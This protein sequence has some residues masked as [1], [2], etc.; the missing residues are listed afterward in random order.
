MRKYEQRGRDSNKG[1][2]FAYDEIYRLTGVK[3]NSPEPT[4]PAAD[5]YEKKKALTFDDL[6]NIVSIVETM[7]GQAKTITTEIPLDSD[8][9]KLNQYSRFDQ[10]G[11][12]Y[13]KNGNLTQ[14][15]TQKLYHDYRNRLVRVTEG[16]T[17]TENKYDAL[18]RRMQKVVTA[19]SQSKTENYY[20]AGHQVIEVRDGNDQVKRQFIY[21]NG[22]DEVVRLDTYNGSTIAPY[23]FHS[24]GIG[25]TTAVTEA[26]G[27]VVER[28]QYDFYGMPTFMDA[29]SN[30]IPNSAI[31]NNILFQGREYEPE[32]NFYYY[33][34]RHFDPIM[35]R[36]LQVDPMGYQDSLN[37]YQ[38]F[39]MNPL[40]FVD[41]M[42]LLT[43][44][45]NYLGVFDENQNRIAGSKNPEMFP[46]GNIRNFL[47][48]NNYGIQISQ[49]VF[50]DD[51]RYNFIIA[52]TSEFGNENNKWYPRF[53]FVFTSFIFLSDELNSEKH[54]QH[55]QEHILGF[56][57]IF[58]QNLFK[59]KKQEEIGYDTLD[60]CQNAA[61]EFIND[62]RASQLNKPPDWWPN[63][64][65]L[66]WWLYDIITFPF[67]DETGHFRVWHNFG[68]TIDAAKVAK[69][70]RNFEKVYKNNSEFNIKNYTY[71]DEI[72]SYTSSP[73]PVI[74]RKK[75]PRFKDSLNFS[76][77]NNIRK[78]K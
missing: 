40:N 53:T 44:F 60:E 61:N 24:N 26:N 71:P 59:L 21:G 76:P 45:W 62:L 35:G 77:F 3:F 43:Y 8:Y 34:A 69:D 67:P 38:A 20:Y 50:M 39:N 10:W 48:R 75:F 4:D 78:K 55:E 52:D 74:I 51:E 54:L 14:R 27:Q 64:N 47:R 30:V 16:T 46:N 9:I 18:G 15:G 25:S 17:T 42:G 66:A 33:R 63:N 57:V 2:V 22:I 41:P 73:F 37:L 11:L 7:N 29:A 70:I 36:F 31:G 19:G 56:Q 65:N 28:Y 13:D 12:G 72:D 58:L 23:Y 49:A 32:T 68:D 6:S 5:L 1:D